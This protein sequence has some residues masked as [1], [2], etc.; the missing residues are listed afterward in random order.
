MADTPIDAHVRN[1]QFVIAGQ[2]VKIGAT[3]MSMAPVPPNAGISRS[4]RSCT[5]PHC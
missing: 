2:V 5:D 4:T 1:A 3:T